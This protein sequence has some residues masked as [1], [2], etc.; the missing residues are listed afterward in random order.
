MYRHAIQSQ[1]IFIL[2]FPTK[3]NNDLN[4][5]PAKDA[6]FPYSSGP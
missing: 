4:T 3:T 1:Y 2:F 6:A 5:R